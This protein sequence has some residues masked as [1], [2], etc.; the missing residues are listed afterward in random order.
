MLALGLLLAAVVVMWA[1]HCAIAVWAGKPVR[2]R[3]D[4]KDLSKRQR[5]LKRVVTN[6]VILAVI[7]VYPLA[8][9]EHPIRYFAEQLPTDER[10]FQGLHG[11]AAAV[12]YLGLI[13][14]GWLASDNVRFR[15]RQ[16]PKKTLKRVATTPLSAALGALAEELLF[17]G[18][19]LADLLR[20][21]PA[22]PAVLVG[23]FVFAAAHYVRPVKRY[24]T[25]PGHLM[26]GMLLCVAYVWT[27]MLWLPVGLHAG[28]IFMTLG[29]RPFIRYKGP[30]WLVGES[31]FPYAGAV[32]VVGL[33]L[34]TLWTWTAYGPS[35]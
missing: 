34:L 13:Y 33:A 12:C 10:A 26:L 14:L 22:L 1:G 32:G 35:I 4:T 16:G 19:V 24:W 28:G 15:L 20:W 29:T 23:T 6:G 5:Q 27:D 2:L 21:M 11:F 8:R 9:G 18:V 30:A 31:I 17:R 3:F 7:V 25:I